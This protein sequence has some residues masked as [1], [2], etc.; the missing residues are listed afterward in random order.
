MRLS[1]VSY[2]TATLA[3][4]CGERGVGLVLPTRSV[5]VTVKVRERV[6]SRV[7]VETISL[8]TEGGSKYFGI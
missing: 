5:P 3:S 6:R 1:L 4:T 2:L 8:C 7:L